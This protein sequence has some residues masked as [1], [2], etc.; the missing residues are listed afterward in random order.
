MSGVRTR[1]SG[2]LNSVARFE[3][4]RFGGTRAEEDVIRQ[5]KKER[6]FFDDLEDGIL[7]WGGGRVGK[8]IK[9]KCWKE[10]VS[11]DKA[12]EVMR[13]LHMMVIPLENCSEYVCVNEVHQGR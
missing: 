5:T 4:P 1:I 7:D 8:R 9:V 2:L 6:C 12:K 13:N 3:C 10:R 11:L